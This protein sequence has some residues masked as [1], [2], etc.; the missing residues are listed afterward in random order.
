[1]HTHHRLNYL[2]QT[3]MCDPAHTL[4][5]GD[6]PSVNYEKERIGDTLVYID[7]CKEISVLKEHHEKWL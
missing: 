3:L 5:M 1:H 6:F 4:E 7:W 2:R